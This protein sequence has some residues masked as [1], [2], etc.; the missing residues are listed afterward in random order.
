MKNVYF[1]AD[2]HLGSW[3]ISHGRMRERRIVN[4]LDGIKHK[5]AAVYM[6]GDMFDFWH[7]YKFVVPKGYTR[8]LGK[9]SELTDM[10]VEVHFFTGNHDLW[11]GDYLE[12]ECGVIMHRQMLTTEIEGKV[13]F[14]AHGDGLDSKDKKYLFLRNVFH[15]RT[16]QRLFAS[17]HPRWGMFFGLNWAKNSRRKHEEVEGFFEG[18]EKDGI[19]IFA[20][21]YL[22]THPDINYFLFGHRHIDVDFMLNETSRFIILGDWISKFTYAIFDGERLTVEHFIEG[23]TQL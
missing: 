17:I 23:E 11:C 3:A 6:L 18:K 16:C 22:K 21:N 14:I 12:R 5:A 4:F 15:N 19:A 20:K 7:E 1:L 13:F 2:A 10:G 8:L 9:I